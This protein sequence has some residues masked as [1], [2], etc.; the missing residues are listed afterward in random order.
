MAYTITVL[1]WSGITYQKAYENVGEM[2]HLLDTLKWGTDYFI[3][4]HPEPNVLY[5][6]VSFVL[7]ILVLEHIYD[8]KI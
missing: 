1:A 4:A 5:G 8:V 6:Q 2:D 7:G 3:K